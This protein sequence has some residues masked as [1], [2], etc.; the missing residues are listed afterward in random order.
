MPVRTLRKGPNARVTTCASQLAHPTDIRLRF[1]TITT[2]LLLVAGTLAAP[3]DA[4]TRLLRVL[5][6][7]E[8][9]TVGGRTPIRADA[10]SW[11]VAHGWIYPTDASIN[12]ALSQRS[13]LADAFPRDVA[14]VDDAIEA[15][16]LHRAHRFPLSR[17]GEGSSPGIAPPN[18]CCNS[19]S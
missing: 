8:Y 16:I 3:L 5:Q 6:E 7:G 19:R 14:E 15:A 17:H 10:P 1:A 9:T 13:D 12:V 11:I 18:R 2:A 4:Q